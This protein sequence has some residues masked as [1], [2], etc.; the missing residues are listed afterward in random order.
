MGLGWEMLIYIRVPKK[1]RNSYCKYG[2][3][4]GL[5][6][7]NTTTVKIEGKVAGNTIYP[8]LLLRLFYSV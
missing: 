2:T 4:A 1:K 5:D 8:A 3:T 7:C 6:D